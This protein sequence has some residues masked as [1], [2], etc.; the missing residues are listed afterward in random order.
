MS[1]LLMCPLESTGTA[2]TLYRSAAAEKVNRN[3]V[4]CKLSFCAADSPHV[5]RTVLVITGQAVDAAELLPLLFN[6]RPALA[7]LRSGKQVVA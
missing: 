7:M 2:E 1:L 5:G 3:A 6:W 4:M